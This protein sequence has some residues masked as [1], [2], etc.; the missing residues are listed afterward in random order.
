MLVKIIRLII[1]SGLDRLGRY[2][3]AAFEIEANRKCVSIAA[4]HCIE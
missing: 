1:T 4:I 3:G 2:K